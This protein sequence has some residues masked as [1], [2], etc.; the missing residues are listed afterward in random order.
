MRPDSTDPCS[1]DIDGLG[2]G[3]QDGHIGSEPESKQSCGGDVQA[4]HPG[5]WPRRRTSVLDWLINGTPQER[6]LDNIFGEFCLR[7]RA[8]GIPV[9]RAVMQLRIL[10]P[11]WFGT[12]VL[13]RPNMNTT[14]LRNIEYG[15][16]ETD[17]Y[18]NSPVAALHSGL[19]RSGSA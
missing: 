11:Q 3:G 2:N 13:W 12:R 9:A 4:H 18:R 6:F 15:I 1:V 14:E 7:L 19:S 16:T 5:Y 17:T 10:H 8:D